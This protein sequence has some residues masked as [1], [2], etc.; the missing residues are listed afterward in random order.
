MKLYTILIICTLLVINNNFVSSQTN[1]TCQTA[2]PICS[3]K[4]FSFP[5]RQDNSTSYFLNFTKNPITNISYPYTGSVEGGPYPTW[6][7][8]RVK[9]NGDFS[10]NVALTNYTSPPHNNQKASDVD[11][12]VYGPFISKDISCETDLTINHIARGVNNSLYI[13]KLDID[14]NPIPID[15]QSY[16]SPSG[17]ENINIKGAKDG[18]YYY[19]LITNYEGTY[20]DITLKKNVES[21]I[22]TFDCD[23]VTQT[24]CDPNS[25]LKYGQNWHFGNGAS[26]QF[27]SSGITDKT[28][29]AL[30]NLVASNSISDKYGNLLFYTD[31]AKVYN[32]SNILM[33]GGNL[34]PNLTVLSGIQSGVICPYP[35]AGNENK[36]YIFTVPKQTPNGVI[37]MLKHYM[38]VDMAENGG[39]GKVIVNS[40]TGIGVTAGPFESATVSQTEKIDIVK[41]STGD[42]YWLITANHSGI[43]VYKIDNT[44]FNTTPQVFPFPNGTGF[45]RTFGYMQA[46]PSGRLLALANFRASNNG[47]GFGASELFDFNPATGLVSNKRSIYTGN[48]FDDFY[49]VEFS[50]DENLIY[51]T[52]QGSLKQSGYPVPFPAALYQYK[53]SNSDM[54][55]PLIIYPT[56]I[57]SFAQYVKYQFG[58]LQL[59][60]D[61]KIYM[62]VVYPDLKNKFLGIIN[63]PDANGRICNYNIFGLALKS[64]N[65]SSTYSLPNIPGYQVVAPKLI[66]ATNITCHNT[67]SLAAEA[68]ESYNWTLPDGTKSTLSNL[69]LT[70]AAKINEGVY[71]V[72]IIKEPGCSVTKT[73]KITVNC[74]TNCTDCIPSFSPIPG[75]KYLISGWIKKSLTTPTN[76]YTNVGL[77]VHFKTRA[78]DTPE[79]LFAPSGPIIDGW[80]RV[81]A[82]FDIPKDAINIV[83]ELVNDDEN[84]AAY[85]DDIRVHPYNSNM[86]SFVYDP[87]SQKLVAELDENNYATK[88]EY[89][90]EGILIR[91]K[92]ETERGVMTIKETRNNQ[93]KLS[94]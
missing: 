94:K 27:T 3:D 58:A 29:S 24:V 8:F 92:K 48:R 87:S 20:G 32:K 90:D 88:Y 44:G 28:G 39:L 91:V 2:L 9:N 63:N 22:T 74:E 23:I 64:T 31:G 89:D 1:K 78:G 57:N 17:T 79:S 56:D 80:Q 85:F 41:N 59:G 70:D 77:G 67:I 52:T 53:I 4:N 55:A 40:Y 5:S 66:G 46:S 26:M 71:T 7:Y 60:P 84:V 76:T 93:S 83:L 49:G 12:V 69:I 35:G 6:W 68:G 65:G 72:E 16:F 34:F 50:P 73:I 21:E 10:F 51:F 81:E 37:P 36:Y 45:G 42:G 33:D 15:V 82:S 54:N 18:E 61:G 13:G 25:S 38:I 11:V 43:L 86:K 14:D 62:A 19:I 47:A 75:N 30:S